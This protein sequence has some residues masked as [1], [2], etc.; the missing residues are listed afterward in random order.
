MAG[1]QWPDIARAAAVAL[2]MRLVEDRRE[3]SLGLR[4]LSDLRIVFGDDEAKTT[5]VILDKLQKLDESP[6]QDINGRPLTDRGL[7]VRLRAYGVKPR[8]IRVGGTTP[9]GYRRDDFADVWLRYLPS[10]C[11]G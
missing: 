1:R 4:L 6:W 11:S 5:S 8:V 2:V 7:A 9:R 10:P 3:A